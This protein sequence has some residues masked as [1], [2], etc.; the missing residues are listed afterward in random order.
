MLIV[1]T[2]H[3]QTLFTVTASWFFYLL[4][5]GGRDQLTV[6]APSKCESLYSH[7]WQSL[8]YSASNSKLSLYSIVVLFWDF[9]ER[10]STALAIMIVEDRN[11]LVSTV[12]VWAVF[13]FHPLTR[14]WSQLVWW[15]VW[16]SSLFWGQ[17]GLLLE[18]WLS[19]MKFE[20]WLKMM[21]SLYLFF[22]LFSVV[23]CL[24]L[25]GINLCRLATHVKIKLM[26]ISWVR[27]FW[28]RSLCSYNRSQS[29]MDFLNLKP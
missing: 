19:W 18:I 9:T 10:S 26:G 29:Q 6:S 2:I 28:W 23:F 14:G 11:H 7:W 1:A 8:S 4:K 3:H 15:L 13:W 12:E 25:I 21:I 20:I 17:R 27:Y 22:W 24:V 5:T 16:L